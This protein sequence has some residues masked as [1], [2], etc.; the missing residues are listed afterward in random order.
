VSA[1][2]VHSYRSGFD[3]GGRVKG[4]RALERLLVALKDEGTSDV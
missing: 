1:R 3:Q 4:I 2:L